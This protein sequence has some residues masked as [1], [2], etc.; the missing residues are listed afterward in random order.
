MLADTR[1]KW[2]NSDSIRFI[3]AFHR[4]HERQEA[5]RISS[6][7]QIPITRAHTNTIDKKT[8]EEIV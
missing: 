6:A 4:R 7:L 3:V 2:V 8:M 1:E 5:T